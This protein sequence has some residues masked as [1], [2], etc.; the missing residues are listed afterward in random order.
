MTSPRIAELAEIIA[1][2][3]AVLT[4]YLRSNDLPEPSFASDAPIDTFG[5]SPDMQ[6]AKSSVIEATIEL[7]QL[8]EGPVKLLL[9]EVSHA[10]AP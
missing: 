1:S 6:K 5:S 3:T 7:R 2:Q 9:P 10:E 4:H 8:L